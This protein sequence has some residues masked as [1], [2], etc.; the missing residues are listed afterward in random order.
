MNGCP[1]ALAPMETLACAIAWV[2]ITENMVDQPFL[3]K[4][5]VGYDEKDAAR[6]RTT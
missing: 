6:Q 3:D 5:R 4:D 1:F 2:L